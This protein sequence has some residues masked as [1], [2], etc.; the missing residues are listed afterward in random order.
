MRLMQADSWGCRLNKTCE[1]SKDFPDSGDRNMSMPKGLLSWRATHGHWLG[2]HKHTED[3]C[4]NNPNRY[5]LI[6]TSLRDMH[7]QL[8]L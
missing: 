1:V 6:H 5:N 8:I 2:K 4:V 7:T 3:A